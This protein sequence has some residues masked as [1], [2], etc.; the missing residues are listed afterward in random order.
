MF[1]LYNFNV[2]I[3]ILN[4]GYKEFIVGL[5]I[6]KVFI[7]IEYFFFERSDWFWVIFCFNDVVF[8]MI[9]LLEWKFKYFFILFV[10]R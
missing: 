4:I 2:L 7:F 8:W 5:I 1:G 9:G 3:I 6:V 10:Y